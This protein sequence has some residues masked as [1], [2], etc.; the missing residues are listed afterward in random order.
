MSQ[1][2]DY[3][4]AGFKPVISGPY[5]YPGLLSTPLKDVPTKVLPLVFSREFP[6]RVAWWYHRKYIQVRSWPLLSSCLFFLGF[7]FVSFFVVS[8]V[9]MCCSFFFLPCLP[10]LFASLL[11]WCFSFVFAFFGRFLFGRLGGGSE[12]DTEP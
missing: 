11:F 2:L 5:Q 9:C 3:Q 1:P 7:A 6:A 12:E 8:F 4:K 10:R